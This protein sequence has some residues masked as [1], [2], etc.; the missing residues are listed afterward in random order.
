MT[1]LRDRKAAKL[2]LDLMRALQER[3]ETR[4]LEEI[5]ARELAAAVDIS[6]GT[7]FNHFPSKAALAFYFVQL[8]SIDAGFHARAAASRGA[9]AAIE[10]IFSATAK[11]AQAHPRVMAEI[12]VLQARKPPQLELRRIGPVERALAFPG[13]ADLDSLGDQGLPSLLPPLIDRAIREGELPARTDRQAAFLALV[14][15]F[16]GVP[17]VLG[18]S[19]PT[20]I[21]RAYRQQLDLVWKGLCHA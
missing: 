7:F 12:I 2:R 15:V 3:L 14:N 18:P 16:F 6:E 5:S 11:E 17:L 1:A 8:W 9:R 20:R 19:A 4:G 13:R 10:A 21:G